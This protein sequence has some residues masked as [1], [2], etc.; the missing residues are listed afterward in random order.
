MVVGVRELTRD[1]VRSHL[2]ESV[3]NYF[4]A[5]GFDATTVEDAARAAGISRAT[6]FRYFTSKED[7]VVVALESSQLDFGGLLSALS[8]RDGENAWSLL[9]RA[10]EPAADSADNDPQRVR[11]KA[12][13]ITSIPSLRSHLGERRGRQED[14]LVA[15]LGDR[16]ADPLTARVLVVAALSAFDLAWREWAA[17]P[18]ASLRAMLDGVFGRLSEHFSGVGD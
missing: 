8:L 3:Y 2:A 12:R 17:D 10:F 13:M 6:F 9:R 1:T 14:I 7:A 16:V 15:A 11:A 18:D 4:L 5:N